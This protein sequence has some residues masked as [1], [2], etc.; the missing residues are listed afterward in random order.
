M[1]STIVTLGCLGRSITGRSDAGTARRTPTELSRLVSAAMRAKK[2]VAGRKAATNDLGVAEALKLKA[3]VESCS[4]A[5]LLELFEA[6]TPC[7]GKACKGRRDNPNC[8]CGLAPAP[9]AF[10]RKGLWQKDPSA[11]LCL[12]GADPADLQRKARLASS[13]LLTAVFQYHS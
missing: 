11:L 10:R 9:G 13:L 7:T 8:L 4:E 1:R 6:G 3:D 2:G 12:G 5:Q